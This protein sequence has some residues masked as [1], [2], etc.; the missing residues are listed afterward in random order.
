MNRCASKPGTNGLIRLSAGATRACA[1]RKVQN[2]L[3]HV[4]RLREPA[5]TLPG[6]Q[7]VQAG[8]SRG[9]GGRRKCKYLP[10][11]INPPTPHCVTTTTG[12]CHR[13]ATLPSHLSSFLHRH[14]RNTV[15]EFTPD[16]LTNSTSSVLIPVLFFLSVLCSLST[17]EHWTSGASCS[18]SEIIVD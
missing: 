16:C 13:P 3:L 14:V 12:K 17:E 18:S 10:F 5:Q 7:P 8:H 11:L 1:Q 6:A 9:E 15:S 4:H 2:P